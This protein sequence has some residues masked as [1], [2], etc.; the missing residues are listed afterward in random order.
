MDLCISVYY[1][2]IKLWHYIIND[3]LFY[4]ISR[5]LSLYNLEEIIKTYLF[6]VLKNRGK[7]MFSLLSNG[8]GFF[9]TISLW[10]IL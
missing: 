1:V 8:F 3:I 4:F 10:L 5:M 2:H 9:Q 7:T 6:N